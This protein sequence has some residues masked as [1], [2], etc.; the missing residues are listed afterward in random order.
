[1]HPLVLNIKDNLSNKYMLYFVLV[2]AVFALS[3]SAFAQTPVPLEIPTNDIFEQ[4]NIWMGVFAPIVAIGIGIA[5][6]L[7]ILTFIGKQIIN[8]FH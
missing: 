8:A 1:M 3:I 5:V 4:T 7:A 6:A 2:A